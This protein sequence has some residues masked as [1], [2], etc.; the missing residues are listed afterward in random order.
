MD[1]LHQR[2]HCGRAL[3]YGGLDMTKLS[4]IE[5]GTIRQINAYYRAND[6]SHKWPIC[7]KFNVTE[8]AIRRLRACQHYSGGLEYFMAL[9][10]EI[11]HIVNSEVM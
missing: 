4:D 8:R 6:E 5:N 11:S 10:G 1:N 2:G 3:H 9:D 7:N